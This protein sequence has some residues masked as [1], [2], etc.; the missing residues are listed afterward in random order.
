MLLELIL[1]KDVGLFFFPHRPSER[2]Y[3]RISIHAQ[4]DCLDEA[5]LQDERNVCAVDC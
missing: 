5:H 4:E 1:V 3:W 2:V